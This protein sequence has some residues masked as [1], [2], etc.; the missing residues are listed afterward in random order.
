MARAADYLEKLA[1]N[2]L[3]REPPLEISNCL[4]APGPSTGPGF[5]GGDVGGVSFE[6]VPW[7]KPG[8]P[9]LKCWPS[10]DSSFFQ[11]LEISVQ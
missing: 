10:G 7:L 3:P 11:V 1:R 4:P 8:F 2:E 6:P 5:W 9:I